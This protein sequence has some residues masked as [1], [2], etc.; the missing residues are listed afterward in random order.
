MISRL[1][2]SWAA[3]RTLLGPSWASLGPLLGLS[4]APLGLSWPLLG[5]SWALL[6]GAGRDKKRKKNVSW[7]LFVLLGCSWPCLGLILGPPELI[8]RPLGQYFGLSMAFP[9]RFPPTFLA[10]LLHQVS[11]NMCGNF[12]V[13]LRHRFAGNCWELGTPAHGSNRW[14]PPWV[15]RS[16]RS[17]LQ[18][19]RPSDQEGE[20]VLNKSGL[21]RPAARKPSLPASA[22]PAEVAYGFPSWPLIWRLVGLFFCP[23][24]LVA[25][26]LP[27][28][29]HF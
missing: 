9:G 27:S 2:A 5:R 3:L 20:G 12:S 19:A 15:R 7:P 29:L 8:L 18:S 22:L 23:S 14:E 16:P 25:L 10:K 6:E 17:G 11:R 4:W 21:T 1:I 26:F 28:C 13:G 24:F